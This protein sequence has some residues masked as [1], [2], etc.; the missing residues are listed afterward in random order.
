MPST[1][2][3]R[4]W[5]VLLVSAAGLCAV[6]APPSSHAQEVP[7]A[8]VNPIAR[9]DSL[10]A[11]SR[12]DSALKD[13]E[14]CLPA[15]RADADSSLLLALLVRRGRILA[16]ADWAKEAEP[17]L[18]EAVTLAEA[19]RD[20]AALC[21]ALK[22]LEV[23]VDYLGRR[24]EA[25]RICTRLREVAR[26]SG[27]RM[28]EGWALFGLGWQAEQEDRAADALD[29]YSQALGLF[30]ET[31]DA[32]GEIWAWNGMGSVKQETGA[33]REATVCFQK[34]MR[35]AV[36][37]GHVNGELRALNNL[38]TVEFAVG[39]PAKALE[40]FQRAYDLQMR[41]G[42]LREAVTP[43]INV[44]L[45]LSWLRRSQEAVDGLNRSLALCIAEG[46]RDLELK[47][48]LQIARAKYV[49]GDL[50]EAARSY[51]E[52][53]AMGAALSPRTILQVGLGL[54]QT[55]ADMDSSAAA[56]VAL[57]EAAREAKAIVAGELKVHF[58]GTRAQRLLE[59][60][61]PA[62]ALQT[63][64]D[65]QAEGL[66]LGLSY[67]RASTLIQMA[68]AHRALGR[69]DSCLV[70]LERAC[71]A[72]EAE[73]KVPTQPEWREQRG[74]LGQQIYTD[75]AAELIERPA[76]ATAHS[77]IAEAFDRLQVFKARTLLERMRGPGIE[78]GT[79]ASAESTET[80]SV[81]QLQKI[82]QPNEVF[83]DC[84]VG[85]DRSFVFG[86][87]QEE[88]RYAAIPGRRAL[89]PRVVLYG[90]ILA[91]EGAGADPAGGSGILRRT[92]AAIDSTLLGDMGG[93]LA[94]KERIFIS[95]DGPLHR[96]PFG[97]ASALEASTEQKGDPRE[98]ACWVRVPSATL[99]WRIRTARSSGGGKVA[100]RALALLGAP[101]P[102]GTSLPGAQ[103][104]VGRLARLY[105]GVETRLP[106]VGDAA[107][108]DWGALEPY[109]LLHFA[110]HTHVL[111]Q[112]P[113]QSEIEL[114]ADEGSCLQARQ[115]AS[116][117]LRA[118]LVV[119]SSCESAKGVILSGE[120][121][122][123]LTSAFLAAG[124]PAVVATL[125]PVDDQVTAGMMERFY[126]ALA[127]G[128]TCGSALS[129]AQ[130]AVRRNPRTAAPFYWAG[131]IL[132]GDDRTALALRR[133]PD[134]GVAIAATTMLL[135]LAG[136]AIGLRR[137]GG[138][139]VR[140]SA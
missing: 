16:S 1:R 17:I 140:I 135:A 104:E 29:L 110:A 6:V 4:L 43:A 14:Q 111:D 78:I 114:G 27:D 65:V 112:A 62:E 23:S 67:D 12:A 124:V 19:L 59:V 44:A 10:V 97:V 87:T 137:R 3:A 42:N 79:D 60:G 120:G 68:R 132:V 134:V 85:K 9:I 57:D 54:S 69:R 52:L 116:L 71:R 113:W 88:V 117:H 53:L 55:L 118:T 73:R 26:A 37:V 86:I 108:A 131:F 31:G 96:I 125:W 127:D 123:G 74:T 49:H 107:R 133:R 5:L 119:L 84:Y 105:R 115:V 61:R 30:Q 36:E 34:S 33:F 75:L 94:G 25:G 7:A 76:T 101:R 8:Q 22:W 50:P 102:D 18:A 20:S 100:Q 64:K 24:V 47:L 82:L 136:L 93:I 121:V 41:R 83:L 81:T 48:K 92:A 129:L 40:A 77:G 99:L 128:H 56:L 139:R 72:W 126:A 106:S 58:Q 80:I 130:A 70:F 15:A 109:D 138:S 2:T 11:A 90:E 63:L 39:D 103:G 32:S 35:R 89:A 46:W 38:G 45:C 13:I 21:Q 51:R 28:H 122:T 95:P 66:R 98:P 91:D